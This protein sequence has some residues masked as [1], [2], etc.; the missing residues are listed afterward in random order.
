MY[1]CY[2]NEAYSNTGMQASGAT[3]WASSTTTTPAGSGPT[4][5]AIGSHQRKKDM[6]AIALAHG[7]KY[8]AQSTAGYLDDIKR[9]VEK[10]ANT[11]GPSYIQ[12]L[13]PCIP[14]WRVKPD[15]TLTVSRLAAQTGLYPLLEY[16][17]GELIA[18]MPVPKPTPKVDEYLKM[19]G[20]FAHLFKSKR[21]QEQL[22]YI[23]QLANNN[24]KKY[25]L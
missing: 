24:I 9:K 19:Q 20:R 11:D 4:I 14:G 1:V 21:G 2:D 7:L 10:A 17:N 5:D 12:I 25:G 15:Q 23:Q 16:E 22:K 18:K 13:T 6:I 8:V 3:P